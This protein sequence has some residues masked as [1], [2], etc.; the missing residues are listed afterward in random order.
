MEKSA[1]ITVR[2]QPNAKRTEV[3]RF[4]DGVL[5]IKVAA[6][7]VKG[8]ANQ[9]LIAFLSDIL[10]VSRSRLSIEKSA[11]SRVKVIAVEGMSQKEVAGRIQGLQT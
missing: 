9:A 7:P 4:E 8:K 5:S 1:R 3:V 10:G 2:V 11:T 6:P